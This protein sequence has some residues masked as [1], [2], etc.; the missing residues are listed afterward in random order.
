[1]FSKAGGENFIMKN[2]I[3]SD[4][5]CKSLKYVNQLDYPDMSYPTRFDREDREYGKNTTV[6]TSGCGLASSVMVA[7]YLLENCNFEIE[8]AV[9]LSIENGANHGIGTDYKIYSKAFAQ[10]MGITVESNRDIEH[11]KECI[12]N[13]SAAVVHCFKRPNDNYIPL[14]TKS[15]H[16]IALIGIAPDGRAVVL[17]P[18]YEKGKYD[19]EGRNGRAE[20]IEDKVVLCDF[21]DLARE[22]CDIYIFTNN[23]QG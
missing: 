6:A 7:H 9:N 5:W 14:F 1:M 13:G 21:N 8:V 3:L 22:N 4:E 16:Y 23:F 2:K 15:G 17:D 19:I 10:K 20:V 11:L 12:K 18:S